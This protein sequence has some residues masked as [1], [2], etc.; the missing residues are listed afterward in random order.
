MKQLEEK[1]VSNSFNEP[2]LRTLERENES[3]RNQLLF[4]EEQARSFEN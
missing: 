2:K 3:L 1:H 4:L